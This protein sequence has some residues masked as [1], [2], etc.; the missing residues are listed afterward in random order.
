MKT[1]FYKLI[2]YIVLTHDSGRILLINKRAIMRYERYSNM[3]LENTKTRLW[4]IDGH[5]ENIQESEDE[6]YKMI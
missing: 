4:Y 2:G 6:I 3:Y 1:I 5:F